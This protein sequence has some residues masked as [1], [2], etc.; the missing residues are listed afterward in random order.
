M[1]QGHGVGLSALL[2]RA[3]SCECHSYSFSMNLHALRENCSVLGLNGSESTAILSR[4][5]TTY[6]SEA[7]CP[8][9]SISFV[10]VRQYLFLVLYLCVSL[11]VYM[12][13]SMSVC[14][15]LCVYE[16][17]TESLELSQDLRKH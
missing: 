5:E 14:V 1:G 3:L 4:T 15:H 8:S 13:V 9:K 17:G 7:G 10:A 6:P 11:C 2:S 12:C 16:C